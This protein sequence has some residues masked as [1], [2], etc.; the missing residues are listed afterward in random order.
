MASYLR[1]IVVDDLRFYGR[2]AHVS[3]IRQNRLTAGVTFLDELK[4]RA[5]A[6]HQAVLLFKEKVGRGTTYQDAEELARYAGLRPNT[7]R[8]DNDYNAYIR[9]RMGEPQGGT[10][11]PLAA[12]AT[13]G[14]GEL[15]R[16]GR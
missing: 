3:L 5:P 7:L 1:Q 4:P 8:E 10:E 15:W 6:L 2:D 13:P 16:N 11:R 14:L 9:E 12:G